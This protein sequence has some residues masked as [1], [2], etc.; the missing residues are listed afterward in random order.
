MT[1]VWLS[2]SVLLLAAAC[3][4]PKAPAAPPEL[5]S[6]DFALLPCA[7]STAEA[8]CVFIAA[9]G[10]RLLAGAP[11][12]IRASLAADPAM[13]ANIDAV[14][15]FSLQGAHV[16]GLDEV[17]NT[18]WTAGRETPLPVAGPSGTRDL[19]AAL[20]KAFELSDAQV[21]VQSRPKGGFD[22]ALLGLLPGEGDAKTVVF[23]TGDLVVTKLETA[24][25]MAGYWVDYGGARA[26]LQPCGMDQAVRFGGEADAVLA[27]E[28]EAAW[29]LADLHYILQGA[30]PEES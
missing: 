8:P 13:A 28:G 14:L 3:G 4:G 12:G 5:K 11:P 15:L 21:F 19:L 18:T 23:D 22:A 27:C 16:E 29:P 20:N 1:R 24:A 7:P 10:K 2:L 17:R 6:T 26:V 9:G 25:G 30:D